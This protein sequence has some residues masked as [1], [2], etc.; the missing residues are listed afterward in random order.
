MLPLQ[1]E[2]ECFKLAMAVRARVPLENIEIILAD[3]SELAF[4]RLMEKA[5]IESALGP[6][7]ASTYKEIAG[8][9]DD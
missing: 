8:I 2:V 4:E 7:F 6:I 3:H 1:G 9:I 5:E